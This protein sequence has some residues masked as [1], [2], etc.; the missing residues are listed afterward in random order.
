MTQ[1]EPPAGEQRVPASGDD[2][3]EIVL[4]QF[5][6]PYWPDGSPAPLHAHEFE[7]GYLVYATYPPH[8][9]PTSPPPNPGGSNFVVRKSNGDVT[10]VPNYPTEMAI[11][12]YRKFYQ[13]SGSEG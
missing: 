11:E 2:A 1:P 3:I 12:V 7:E 13:P 5:A 4:E 10:T 6:R 8:D 9:D